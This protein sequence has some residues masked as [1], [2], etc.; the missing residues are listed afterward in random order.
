[1]GVALGHRAG[2]GAATAGV[3]R[4]TRHGEPLQLVLVDVTATAATAALARPAGAAGERARRAERHLLRG[5][6]RRLHGARGA[7]GWAL[8]AG[9]GPHGPSVSGPGAEGKRPLRRP[10][11]CPYPRHV[12]PVETVEHAEP[13]RTRPAPARAI[14]APGHADAPR[15]PLERLAG[16]LG[17]QGFGRLLSRL[18]DGDGILAGGRVHPDVEAAIAASHGAGQ[19]L[20]MRV[21]GAPRAVA[22]RSLG[23]VR[24]HTDDDAAALARAVSAR[25]FT[26]GSDIFFGVGRVPA[27]ARPT[28]TS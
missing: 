13:E 18:Q 20:D 19:A 11:R 27:R 23:D 9:D 12:D 14:E 7:G 25:A 2:E 4:R 10:C 8:F 16:G 6:H 3:D 26:V 5:A 28:A 21:V 22:R 1:M 24:V 15:S 17:N